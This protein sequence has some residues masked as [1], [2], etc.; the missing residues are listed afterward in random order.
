MKSRIWW[1]LNC[2]FSLVGSLSCSAELPRLCLVDLLPTGCPGYCLGR[3]RHGRSGHGLAAAVSAREWF[4]ICKSRRA[5]CL[6]AANRR[7]AFPSFLYADD[8]GCLGDL[9]RC[10]CAEPDLL[11]TLSCLRLSR[12]VPLS[13]GVEGAQ[14]QV[15]LVGPRTTANESRPCRSVVGD[16]PGLSDAVDKRGRGAC[17]PS[18]SRL[19]FGIL[20]Q[21]R[22][23]DD[24]LAE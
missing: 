5:L 9:S 23:V 15:F 17:P 20:C 4:W 6:C 14:A 11:G 21:S 19:R 1:L 7:A 12:R 8:S 10:L 3:G 16:S 2:P 13:P 24:R 18:P 22:M